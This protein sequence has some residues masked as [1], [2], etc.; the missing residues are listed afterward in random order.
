MPP[1]SALL[2]SLVLVLLLC[3]Q[4]LPADSG[5]IMGDNWLGGTL[6]FAFQPFGFD[7]PYSGPL[8]LGGYYERRH[9]FGGLFLGGQAAAYGFYPRR[10]DFDTSFML[11]GGI[12]A[13]WEF[14]F[15]IERRFGFCV[16]PYVSGR[17]YWRRFDYQGQ[18]FSAVR[19]MV[20]AGADLD[21]LIRRR[22]HFGVNFELVLILDETLR[23]TL[24][25]GQR[26]G[27]RF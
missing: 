6:C 16:S 1:R 10:E 5:Q 23:L 27:V 14:S 20:A 15:P 12:K 26:I 2:L 7:D 18:I 13:G 22:P 21:L 4:V 9:V 8:G 17:Y 24:G 25:Q 19:P 11:V 3:T